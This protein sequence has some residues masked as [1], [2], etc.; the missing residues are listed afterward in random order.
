M[1]TRNRIQL[2]TACLLAGLF[3]A[4]SQAD[5]VV[6]DL[7]DAR[8][9]TEPGGARDDNNGGNTAS[10]ALIGINPG[11]VDNFMIYD[12]SDLS[13]AS[14]IT[15][16]GATVT[17]FVEAIPANNGIG[18]GDTISLHEIALGNSGWAIGNGIITAADTPA[19]NGSVSFANRV[20]FNGS[21]TTEAWVDA[22]GT[23]VA[24]VLGAFSLIETISAFDVAPVSITFTVDAATAQSWVD[25]GLGG[26]GLSA[27][28]GDGDDMS[29]L[30][31]AQAGATITFHEVPEPGSLALLGLGG[32]ALLRRRRA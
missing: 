18:A 2:T 14:G 12:F 17:V 16:T 20:Q 4:P 10:G 9:V 26:L 8:L 27:T 22:G 15:V 25:N 6:G 32:L 29:R 5:V 11:G 28:D 1:K 19:D 7:G 13:A 3:T 21:G 24:N 30:N 23:D 31:F